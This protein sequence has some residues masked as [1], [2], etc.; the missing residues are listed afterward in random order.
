MAATN[1]CPSVFGVGIVGAGV[2]GTRLARAILGETNGEA[3]VAAICD[4]NLEAANKLA[5]EC[6]Q[7][8]SASIL[9]TSDYKALIASEAG[10]CCIGL[11]WLH[12]FVS[13]VLV[14]RVGVVLGR[15]AVVPVHVVYVG[16]PPSVHKPIALAAFAAQKHVICEK[17]LALSGA[18]AD[19][20]AG[21]AEAAG[22]VS[23]V[24]LP[25]RQAPPVW[26]MCNATNPDGSGYVGACVCMPV[27]CVG[28][29]TP[30]SFL[31]SV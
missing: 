14:Q 13:G 31:C 11:L 30:P 22:V 15:L 10:V 21:A 3:C 28:W 17:P 16:V 29:A 8:G 2:I 5:K 12:G 27:G 23:T 6:E 26:A 4:L 19:E 1:E 25:F 9:V 7:A 18:D 20:M 24:N